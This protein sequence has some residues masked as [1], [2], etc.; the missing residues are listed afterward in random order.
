[1]QAL[2][3]RAQIR[4][5]SVLQISGLSRGSHHGAEAGTR[6]GEWGL[7]AACPERAFQFSQHD[8]GTSPIFHVHKKKAE[9]IK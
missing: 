6:D 7:Q 2:V 9:T 5:H 1:M 3:E 4:P 8:V